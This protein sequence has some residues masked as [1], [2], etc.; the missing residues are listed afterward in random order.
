M[1]SFRE[2]GDT[3]NMPCAARVAGMVKTH[4]INERPNLWWSTGKGALRARPRPTKLSTSEKNSAPKKQQKQKMLVMWL[5]RAEFIP[6]LQLL[7]AVPST[8]CWLQSHE[9]HTEDTHFLSSLRV[10]E[11]GIVAKRGLKNSLPE[12]VESEI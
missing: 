9:G 11:A 6:C 4:T 5:K 2:K 12:A 8:W 1:S 3:S 10:T 7:L